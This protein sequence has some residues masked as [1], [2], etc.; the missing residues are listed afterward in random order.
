ML[1]CRAAD[2]SG[3]Q[4]AYIPDG[5]QQ[6]HDN[7]DLSVDDSWITVSKKKQ[8]NMSVPINKPELHV[9]G[10]CSEPASNKDHTT[11]DNMPWHR[12]PHPPTH[13]RSAAA[14]WHAACNE[15]ASWDDGAA[16]SV[17]TRTTSAWDT[18]SSAA[19][20]CHNVGSTAVDLPSPAR[21]PTWWGSTSSNHKGYPKQNEDWCEQ[22]VQG[23]ALAESDAGPDYSDYTCHFC[24]QLGHIQRFCPAYQAANAQPRPK[25][26]F[27][28]HKC[29][30]CS[31]YGHVAHE[32][33][34]RSDGLPSVAP[35]DSTLDSK[36]QKLCRI[37]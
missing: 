37:F 4:L 8:Q 34:S 31:H 9:S 15:Q 19:G 17:A 25:E 32:H 33:G 23:Q 21:R 5:R 16:D 18:S 36:G 35:Q 29:H 12:V 11:A 26:D 1:T 13:L 20:T 10:W 14:P 30:D 24:Q 27:T 7:S 2:R 6:Q 22:S 3:S 28:F